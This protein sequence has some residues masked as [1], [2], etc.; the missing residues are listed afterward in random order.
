MKRGGRT[1]KTGQSLR[2]RALIT[3]EFPFFLNPHSGPDESG[4]WCH[5]GLAAGNFKTQHPKPVLGHSDHNC[6]CIPEWHIHGIL[7]RCPARARTG[8]SN[9]MK[10]GEVLLTE[11]QNPRFKFIL[12]LGEPLAIGQRAFMASRL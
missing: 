5:I 6:V 9:G 8:R 11:S 10:K 1:Q 3:F 12:D 7:H 2:V 4:R